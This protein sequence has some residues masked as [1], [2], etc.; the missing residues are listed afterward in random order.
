MKRPTFTLG[1]I[2]AV[3]LA[4]VLLIGCGSDKPEASLASAKEYLAKNDPKAAVIELKNALQEK[5]DLAE[6]RFLLGKTLL[7]TGDAVSAEKELRKAAEFKYAPDQVLPELANTIL[8]QGQFKKVIDEFGKSTL[9][10]PE[11]TAKLQ[12][13]IG[14][15]QFALGNREAAAAAFEAATAT[16]SG[17]SPA[18]IG[19]AKLKLAARDLPGALA[20]VDA[21]LTTSPQLGQGWQLK[22]DLLLADAKPE[23]ALAAYRKAVAVSPD[24]L[25]ARGAIVSV[26]VLQGKQDDAAKEVAEMKRIAP[27]H[28]HTLYFEALVAYQQK[29]FTAARDAI[30]KQLQAAPDDL[31]GLLL[32]GSVA[33]ELKSYAQAESNLLKVL[34]AVPNQGFARR[35]LIAT[36]LRTGQP[37]KALETLKPIVDRIDQDSAMLSL[38]G[39]V[40]MQNGNVAEAGRY[41]RL[42]FRSRG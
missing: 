35:A 33:Y 10:A 31:A 4:G 13:V 28:P 26:L 23:E 8:S 24:D 42:V 9:T 2:A 37:A 25:R 21:A 38:A 40:Y 27:K 20:L 11:A 34:Q 1:A 19:Q 36:Y 22:G 6:A 3:L 15:A 14:Q 39:E 12:T 29:N 5:P 32:S 17:Y 16:K 7:N 41:G 18:M 30:Q